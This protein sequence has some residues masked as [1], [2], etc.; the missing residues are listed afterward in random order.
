M[1]GRAKRRRGLL[2]LSRSRPRLLRT[3]IGARPSDETDDPDGA[4][5]VAGD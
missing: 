5:E 4:A 1:E 2:G 3:V